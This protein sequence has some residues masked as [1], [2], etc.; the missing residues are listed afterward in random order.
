MENYIPPT[1]IERVFEIDLGRYYETWSDLDIPKILISKIC[2]NIKNERDREVV[3]K[4]RL[5]GSIS[6]QITAESLKD[7]DAFEEIETFFK[8]VKAIIDGIYVEK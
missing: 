5:N 7:I 2:L 4:S 1:I 6:K 8:K 3:I